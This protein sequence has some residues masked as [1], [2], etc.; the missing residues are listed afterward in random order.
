METTET[1]VYQVSSS[2]FF[3]I[4]E[5]IERSKMW[6]LPLTKIF[7]KRERNMLRPVAPDAISNQIKDGLKGKYLSAQFI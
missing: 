5:N 7:R 2:E 3:S 1:N 4:D 6:T